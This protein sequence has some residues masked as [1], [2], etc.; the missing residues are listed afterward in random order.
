MTRTGIL[1]RM[2]A[3]RVWIAWARENRGCDASALFKQQLRF[4]A[5]ESYPRRLGRW[6]LL[7]NLYCLRSWIT[8]LPLFHT[9]PRRSFQLA[10]IDSRPSIGLVKAVVVGLPLSLKHRR[11]YLRGRWASA[12]CSLSALSRGVLA[13]VGLCFAVE[14]FGVE[15]RKLEHDRPT[16]PDR[17]RNNQHNSLIRVPTS[18]SRSMSP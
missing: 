13:L 8:K 17:R 9:T 11:F 15:A 1:V 3:S 16:T 7:K 14:A 4:G 2:K 18:R 6:T 5:P 10:P 12:W